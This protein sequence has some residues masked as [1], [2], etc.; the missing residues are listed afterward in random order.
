[1]RQRRP[2]DH[3][4]S[5]AAPSAAGRRR[6]GDR[7]P[8]ARPQRLHP[9]PPELRSAQRRPGRRGQRGRRRAA[10][11]SA[12]TRRVGH[13]GGGHPGLP[14][15]GHEPAG[16]LRGGARVPRRAS[17][18]PVDART[19]HSRVLGGAAHHPGRRR[20]ALP[21]PGRG[22][23][24]DRRVRPAD[25]RAAGDHAGL[26]GHGAGTAAGH[27]DHVHGERHAALPG[28]VRTAVRPARARLLRHREALRRAGRAV[29]RQSGHHRDRGDASAAARAGTVS[30]RGGGHGLPAAH[31]HRPG[32]AHGARRRRR[33]GPRR[34][35]PG[36]RRGGRRRPAA[37]HA[38]AAGAD[39]DGP[40]IGQGGRGDRRR[41]PAVHVGRRRPRPGPDRRR[42][43]LGPGGHRHGDGRTRLRAGDQRHAGGR[44]PG[45]HRARSGPPDDV[46]RPQPLRVR[47]P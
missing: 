42:R 10:V 28:A 17:G 6:R 8:G 35:H 30:G 41:R 15:R 37:P 29:V 5:A 44:R 22:R 33:R 1:M 14:A 26:G 40:P 3:R 13:G 25:H 21:D 31:R 36:G 32:R 9:D 12:G 34:P 16:R 11:P 39:P 47:H 43:R 2:D 38:G 19:A 24:G 27:A 20:R 45:R 7:R 4:G 46:R 18:H 23:L